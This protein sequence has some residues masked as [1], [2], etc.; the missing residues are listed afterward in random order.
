MIVVRFVSKY[1]LIPTTF[2]RLGLYKEISLKKS[3]NKKIFYTKEI[4]IILFEMLVLLYIDFFSY[5]HLY[6]SILV[7]YIEISRS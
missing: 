3:N 5:S 1:I 2:V 6:H 4:I 7:S